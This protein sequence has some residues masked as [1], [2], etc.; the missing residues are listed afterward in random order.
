MKIF[1]SLLLYIFFFFNSTCFSQNQFPINYKFVENDCYIIARGTTSKQEFI[2]K[3][4]NSINDSITHIG[5]GLFYNKAFKIFNV[6]AV[7]NSNA[8][9]IESFDSFINQ[10]DLIYYGIW[11]LDLDTIQLSLLSNYLTDIAKK[12]INFDFDF[13]INQNDNNLYCSEFCWLA[14]NVLGSG[15]SFQLKKIQTAELGLDKILKRD[16]LEYVPLDYFLSFPALTYITS[17]WKKK[18]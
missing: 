5:I 1:S 8:L 7:R 2:S 10:E 13:I 17:W 16:I 11:K 9:T 12:N 15:Y 6:N 3:K 18:L 4:F 14:T